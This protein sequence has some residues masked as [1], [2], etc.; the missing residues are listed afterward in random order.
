MWAPSLAMVPLVWI[1]GTV[2][3]ARGYDAAGQL[4][5]DPVAAQHHRPADEGGG[6]V[7]AIQGT[8]IQAAVTALISVPMGI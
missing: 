2:V 6:A 8:L 5:V 1:L 4:L 7:H 3:K